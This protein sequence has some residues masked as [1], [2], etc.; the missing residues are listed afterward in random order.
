MT[1]VVL[2]IIT[3]IVLVMQIRQAWQ[4]DEEETDPK[5]Y[6]FEA[7]L[8]SIYPEGYPS[9][10]LPEQA[11][12]TEDLQSEEETITAAD[13]EDVTVFVSKPEGDEIAAFIVLLHGGDTSLRAAERFS[14]DIGEMLAVNENA[15]VVSVDWRQDS[16]DGVAVADL[17]GVLEW[18]QQYAQL[19][20]VPTI[21]IG[22]G[23]GG[24]IAQRALEE[25]R[26]IDALI[27]AYAYRDPSAVYANLQAQNGD[28]VAAVATNFAARFGCDTAVSAET[29]L[30]DAAVLGSASLNGDALIIHGSADTIVPQAEAEAI[31]AQFGSPEDG[32][33]IIG[34]T[35]APIGHDFFAQ[36]D[37]LGF[38]AASQL[39]VDWLTDYLL[40]AQ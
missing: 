24:Y 22:A 33:R 28:D 39:L 20:T 35:E 40:T 37:S 9:I 17:V 26:E 30:R 25:D 14:Q 3:A 7:F 8:D 11:L 29:C 36:S 10:D 2:G 5:D 6:S 32:A 13:G 19:N 23:H 1:L 27:T 12:L 16:V 34:T 21:V 18:S 31:A 15:V 38:A 4:Q